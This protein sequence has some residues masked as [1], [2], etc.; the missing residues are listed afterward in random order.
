MRDQF[1]Y[2][3]MAEITTIFFDLGHVLVNVDE[4]GAV[5]RIA[6]STRNTPEEIWQKVKGSGL[7]DSYDRGELTPQEFFSEVAKKLEFRG[8]MTFEQMRALWNGIVTS[9]KDDVVRIAKNL[10][11]RYRLFLLSNTDGVHHA[12][13]ATMV[14]LDDLFDGQ[15]V[16]YLVG[17]EKPDAKIYKVALDAANESPENCL[18]IDDMPENIAGA[19]RAGMHG[20]VFRD[21]EQLK[22]EL[23]ELGVKVR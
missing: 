5:Q 12:H 7:L 3:C 11:K 15:I 17:A 20:I 6:R 8:E 18:F 2:W 14:P 16:S 4:M 9:P 10:K 21:V 13:A 19:K 1:F 22:E 23:A